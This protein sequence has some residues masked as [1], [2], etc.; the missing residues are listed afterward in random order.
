MT[1][2]IAVHGAFRGRWYW[3]PLRIELERRGHGLRPVDLVGDS[4]DEW[5]AST[6]SAVEMAGSEPVVLVGHSMGGVVSQVA[7][8]QLG[9]RVQRLVL[10]DSPLV[11]PGQRP[12]DISGPTQPDESMLPPREFMVQPTPVGPE[13]GFDDPSLANWVNERLRPVPM[14]PQLDV[15]PVGTGRAAATTVAFFSRTPDGFPSTFARHRCEADGIDHVVLD[16]FHD[17]PIL[18]PGVVADLL[19]ARL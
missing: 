17:A 14:G 12:V 18:D 13:Q 5:V 16:G 11:E 3:D 2:F 6:I 8:G 15:A 9:G 19:L 1:Q 4:L 10:L 7:V